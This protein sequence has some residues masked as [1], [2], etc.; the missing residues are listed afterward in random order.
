LGFPGTHNCLGFTPAAVGVQTSRV[1]PD[2]RTATHELGHTVRCQDH[3]VDSDYIMYRWM[4][5]ANSQ[6]VRFSQ[7]IQQEVPSMDVKE[8]YGVQP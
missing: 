8:H 6:T 2:L 7:S 3:E 5:V 1:S 4:T